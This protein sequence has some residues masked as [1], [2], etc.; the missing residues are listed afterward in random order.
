MLDTTF[1][2]VEPKKN[3]P[4]KNDETMTASH[5]EATT[6]ADDENVENCP[7][8]MDGLPSDF[9]TNPSLAALASLLDDNA[10]ESCPKTKESQTPTPRAGGGKVQRKP[11]R[12]KCN[13][14][15]Y[16]RDN[17]RQKGDANIGEANLFL[18]MWKL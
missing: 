6:P 8:F 18:K 12:S 2:S 4:K 13:D 7:L 9:A 3:E 10:D 16:K 15:P 17:D 11:N 1:D 14:G 5:T